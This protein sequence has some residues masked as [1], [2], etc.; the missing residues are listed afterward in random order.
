VSAIQFHIRRIAMARRAVG[1]LAALAEK[2]A[3]AARKRRAG[4]K[5]RALSNR[6]ATAVVGAELLARVAAAAR[7]A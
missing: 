5:Y 1:E 2:R 6:E 7:R 4:T 3:A